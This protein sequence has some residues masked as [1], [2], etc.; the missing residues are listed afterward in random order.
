[1]DYNNDYKTK[2]ISWKRQ[3]EEDCPIA[4]P[5]QK[6]SSVTHRVGLKTTAR[7]T[8]YGINNLSCMCFY[9]KW[10]HLSNIEYY[11]PTM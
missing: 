10:A 7:P 8:F 5:C 4:I 2:T 1:M 6:S 11:N 9:L 3:A